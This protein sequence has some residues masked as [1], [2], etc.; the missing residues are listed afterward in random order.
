MPRT[1]RHPDPACGHKNRPELVVGFAAETNDVTAHAQAKLA[2]K[3]CDI[4]VANDVSGD[5]MGGD[6][7]TMILVSADNV[8]KW[9]LMSKT[10]AA[11][12]LAGT[13]AKAL[14]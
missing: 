7:N 4:I 9:P 12:K 13:I 14:V 8:D 2:R 5:V 3:G 11:Q 6:N 10:H 1:P